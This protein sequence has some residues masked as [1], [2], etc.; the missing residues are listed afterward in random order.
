MFEGS[1]DPN[2]TAPS[3]VAVKDEYE[4]FYIQ[5]SPV[6]ETLLAAQDFT[7]HCI[8]CGAVELTIICDKCGEQAVVN[9][10]AD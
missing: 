6:V 9:K 4:A 10:D 2:T 7:R 3:F 1:S 8:R 5:W